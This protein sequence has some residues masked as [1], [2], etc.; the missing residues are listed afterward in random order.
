VMRWLMSSLFQ[1]RQDASKFWLQRLAFGLVLRQWHVW[2]V[3]VLVVIVVDLVLNTEHY[4]TLLRHTTDFYLHVQATLPMPI[5]YLD[6]CIRTLINQ[7]INLYLIMQ[8]PIHTDIQTH[9]H[10]QS[11]TTMFTVRSRNINMLIRCAKIKTLTIMPVLHMYLL[12]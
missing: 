7:S 12:S 3:F 6:H 8:K 1:R 2:V 9:T 10:A 5:L 4:S 11:T